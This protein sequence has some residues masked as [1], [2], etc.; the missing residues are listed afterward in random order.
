MNLQHKSQTDELS[1]FKKTSN[2]LTR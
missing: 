1:T 2:D